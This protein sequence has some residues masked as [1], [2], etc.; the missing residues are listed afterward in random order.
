MA[1]SIRIARSRT[2]RGSRPLVLVDEP[3]DVGPTR[4]SREPFLFEQT[5]RVDGRCDSRRAPP[6]FLGI[7][8]ERAQ[9]RC[10]RRDRYATP[11]LPTF[12]F[13]KGVD[14]SD[15]DRCNRGFARRDVVQEAFDLPPPAADRIR[16]QTA[17]VP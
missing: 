13:E 17:L 3:L 5:R 9:R 8:E 16:R 10:T 7:P 11:I 12:R 4:T 6:S 1:S 14:V 2:S 15:G